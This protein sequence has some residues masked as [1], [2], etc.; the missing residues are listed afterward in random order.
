MSSYI[1]RA[2]VK[3]IKLT[4]GFAFPGTI[5]VNEAELATAIA[6]ALKNAINACEKLESEER[7]IDIKVLDRPRFIIQIVNSYKG[8][9]AFEEDNIPIN[10]EQ[11]YD[12]GT[13]YIAAFFQKDNGF[14]QFKA[15][16]GRFTLYLNF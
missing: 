12:F 5:P 11:D 3:S 4:Y 2:E 1:R 7:Y 9:V 10:E 14:Y 8:D 15:E 6:N 16:N 13:R